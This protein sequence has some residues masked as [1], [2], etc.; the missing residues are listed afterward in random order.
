MLVWKKKRLD[1]MLVDH[2]LRSGYYETA[3]KL[4]KDSQIEVG[5]KQSQVIYLKKKLK[6]LMI[7]KYHSIKLNVA[8]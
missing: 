4:A 2:C 7:E 3:I 6:F 8:L 1:R 5:L